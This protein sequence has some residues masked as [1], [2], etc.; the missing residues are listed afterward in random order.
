MFVVFILVQHL[1]M[2]LRSIKT[3]NKLNLLSWF[4]DCPRARTTSASL[5]KRKHVS[6]NQ[7]Y[8]MA[9]A[10]EFKWN[11]TYYISRYV[12]AELKGSKKIKR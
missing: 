11:I 4:L 6:G 12:D 7:G 10:E 9:C 1:R 8:D 5:N 2:D 3:A